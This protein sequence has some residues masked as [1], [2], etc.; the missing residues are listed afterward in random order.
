MTEDRGGQRRRIW[1]E[2]VNWKDKL[3][4]THWAPY[5]AAED[6]LPSNPECSY[7]RL[8]SPTQSVAGARTKWRRT[9]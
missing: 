5:S 4:R 1:R 3:G 7:S 6:L 2:C 9:S 8:V